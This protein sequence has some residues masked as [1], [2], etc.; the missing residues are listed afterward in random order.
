MISKDRP[1]N[2]GVAI[3]S[4]ERVEKGTITLRLSEA[5]YRQDVLEL[6]TKTAKRWRLHPQRT[7]LPDSI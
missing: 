7:E 4:L 2:Q 1:N 6:T 5:V 3:G